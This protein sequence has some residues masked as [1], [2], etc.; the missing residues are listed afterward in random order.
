MAMFT[1]SSEIWPGIF[2]WFVSS[3]THNLPAPLALME[4]GSSACKKECLSTG[5]VLKTVLSAPTNVNVL[6]GNDAETET[7]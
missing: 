4:M 6:H 2:K 7:I 1:P 3:Y 5:C